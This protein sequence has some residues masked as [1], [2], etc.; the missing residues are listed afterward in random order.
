VRAAHRI[1]GLHKYGCQI[2]G[3]GL[4]LCTKLRER[5]VLTVNKTN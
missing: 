2:P 1:P 5:N 4:V 3:E